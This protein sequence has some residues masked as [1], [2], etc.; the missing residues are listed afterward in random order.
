MTWLGGIFV[1]TL[2]AGVPIIFVL[3]LSAVGYFVVTGNTR[4]L[5]AVP[6]RMF[7]G[8]N[9]FVLLAIP[10]FVLAGNLMDAGGLKRRL[11]GLANALAGRFHGGPSLTAIWGPS[12]SAGSAARR[13]PTPRPWARC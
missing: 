6:R 9:S 11:V 5:L 13:R 4:Q 8:Q 2:L 7:A 3:G 10:L 12:S 1:T